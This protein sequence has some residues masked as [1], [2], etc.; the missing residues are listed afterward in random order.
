MY[1]FIQTITHKVSS[2]VKE[3]HKGRFEESNTIYNHSMHVHF[4]CPFKS[5]RAKTVFIEIHMVCSF[6]CF[7]KAYTYPNTTKYIKEYQKTLIR[8]KFEKTFQ[9]NQVSDPKGFTITLPISVPKL[10]FSMW[11]SAQIANILALLHLNTDLFK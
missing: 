10:H 2:K 8:Q 6:C 4:L 7:S 3:H 9:P 11:L 1:S 5:Y